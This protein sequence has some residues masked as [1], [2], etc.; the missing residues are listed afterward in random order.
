MPTERERKIATITMVL[1]MMQMMMAYWRRRNRFQYLPRAPYRNMDA[2]RRM[3]YKRLFVDSDTY[4]RAQLR[5]GIPTFNRLCCRLK[6]L[7]LKKN[8]SVTVKEQVAMFLHT[9]GHDLRNRINVLEFFR[10][11]E[12]VSRYF[13]IVLNVVLKMHNDVVG[14]ATIHNSP[15]D[16]S[17]HRPWHHFFK[18]AVGAIDGT[19]F[20]TCVPLEDQARYR[21]RNNEIS[22]NVLVACTHDMKFTYVLAGWEGSAHDGRLLRCAV[23]REGSKLNVPAGKYYLADAGFPLV[24]GFLTPYRGV[25][26]HKKDYEKRDPRTPRELYNY[27]HSS[28][29]NVV[30]RTIGVLKKKWAYLRHAPFHDVST[31]T[32]IICACCILHNFLRDDPDDVNDE[33][34][35]IECAPINVDEDNEDPED[36]G[37]QDGVAIVPNDYWTAWRDALAEEMW[38]R[39]HER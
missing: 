20:E 28:L 3:F 16:C 10:S 26:Y 21:D 23:N 11:G 5:M 17:K 9:V 1:M 25:S 38:E 34:L 36:N 18:D 8:R 7:G 30:E 14:P 15:E 4:C 24:P 22:Q 29:R 19:H 39:R 27:R 37:P 2:E 13:H 31:H 35:D 33:G 12:T 6:Q 32:K